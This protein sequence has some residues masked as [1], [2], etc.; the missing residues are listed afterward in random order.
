MR[1]FNWDWNVFLSAPSFENQEWLEWKFCS[2]SHFKRLVLLCTPYSGR[3]FWYRQSI[4]FVFSTLLFHKF[5][6]T[7]SS[8]SDAYQLNKSCC[9]FKKKRDPHSLLPEA[10]LRAPKTLSKMQISWNTLYQEFSP[11]PINESHFSGWQV[12]QWEPVIMC[13]PNALSIYLANYP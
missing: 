13:I 11:R 5:F 3:F 6:L 4:D 2:K 8:L 10:F 7:K 9:R 12:N 1:A